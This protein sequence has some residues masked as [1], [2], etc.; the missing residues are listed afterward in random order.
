MLALPKAFQ[1]QF[2]CS[3][4]SSSAAAGATAEGSV[5][6]RNRAVNRFKYAT[7]CCQFSTQGIANIVIVAVVVVVG[8]ARQPS[9]AQSLTVSP[10]VS[11][12]V[13]LSVYPRA[14]LSV[15]GGFQRRAV[16]EGFHNPAAFVSLIMQFG[17]FAF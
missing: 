15:C 12:T 6:N 7:G 1:F 8:V 17:P 11:L 16:S 2:L 5:A 9:V 14:L 13:L 3:V 10:S 4:S